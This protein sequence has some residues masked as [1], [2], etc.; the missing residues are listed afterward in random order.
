M[1]NNIQTN[2][3][4]NSFDINTFMNFFDWWAKQYMTTT[5]WTIV[6]GSVAGGIV[7]SRFSRFLS[8]LSFL[9]LIWALYKLYEGYSLYGVVPQLTVSNV[10]VEVIK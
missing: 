7:L 9:G 6:I 3:S 2:Q 5:D 8:V 1:V 4:M 10:Y